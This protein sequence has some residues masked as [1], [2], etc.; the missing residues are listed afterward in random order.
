[1]YPPTRIPPSISIICGTNRPDAKSLAVAKAYE[2]GIAALSKQFLDWKP[3]VRLTSMA[4]LPPDFLNVQWEDNA[5]IKA[6]GKYCL[7]SSQLLVFVIPE[8]NGGFPGILKAFLDAVDPAVMKNRTAAIVGVSDGRTGN[9]R[10]SDQLSNVL[11]H[12]KVTVYHDKVKLSGIS[13]FINEEGVAKPE[14]VQML[15]MHVNA[16]LKHFWV[17]Y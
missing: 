14:V 8:Y 1:M 12:M 10:G 6:L 3:E 5:E 9:L 11:N 16:C 17:G 13:E 7:G 2:A 15:S 4:D